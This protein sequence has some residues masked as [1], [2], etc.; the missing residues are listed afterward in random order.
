MQEWWLRLV[1][2]GTLLANVNWIEVVVKVVSRMEEIAGEALGL[3]L[4]LPFL[5]AGNCFGF[6]G[7]AHA[8]HGWRL[9]DFNGTLP[10]FV[11]MLATIT[12][13][14]RLSKPGHLP[15][16][17]LTTLQV[18]WEGVLRAPNVIRFDRGWIACAH[19]HHSVNVE[20]FALHFNR[21]VHL[22]NLR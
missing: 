8:D 2:A 13:S 16:Q 15:F 9:L 11:C 17:R 14:Y 1:M 5:F 7:A 3:A 22:L 19:Y 6:N 12:N 18:A 4:F 20:T 21:P 10:Q